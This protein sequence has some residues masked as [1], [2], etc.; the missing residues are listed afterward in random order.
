MITKNI[1]QFENKI[2]CGDCLEVL[3]TI[4]DETIDMVITSPQDPLPL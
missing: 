3:K 1:K 2:I 4:P